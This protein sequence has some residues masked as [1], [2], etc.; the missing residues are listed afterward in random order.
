VLIRVDSAPINPTDTVMLNG[1]YGSFQ[2]LPWVP[3]TEGSGTVVQSGGGAKADELV[4][5]RVACARALD[6][7]GCWAEYII[8]NVS[9]CVALPDSISL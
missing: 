4:G 7:Y 6:Q 5:K 9:L 2:P 3:G 1:G 8:T